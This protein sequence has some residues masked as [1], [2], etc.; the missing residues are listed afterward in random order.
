MVYPLYYVYGSSS[1][2][3]DTGYPLVTATGTIL[4]WTLKNITPSSTLPQ[5]TYKANTET[6][7]NTLAVIPNTVVVS[8]PYDASPESLRTDVYNIA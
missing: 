4:Q 8:Y 2:P 7:S 6:T 5:I 3:L 1:L